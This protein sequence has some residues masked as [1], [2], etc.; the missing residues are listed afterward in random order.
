MRIRSLPTATTRR[1]DH[2]RKV[3]VNIAPDEPA[4]LAGGAG[5]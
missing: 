2:S 3:M 4:G 5:G 1:G